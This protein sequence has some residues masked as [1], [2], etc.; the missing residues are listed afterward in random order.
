MKMPKIM[1]L[2]KGTID[3]SAQMQ[4]AETCYEGVKLLTFHFSHH[5]VPEKN[6]VFYAHEIIRDGMTMYST[7]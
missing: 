5:Y 6:I 1:E 7:S 3:T 2:N 4:H